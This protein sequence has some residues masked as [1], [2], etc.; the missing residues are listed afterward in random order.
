V[1]SLVM[2]VRPFGH[3][4]LRLYARVS[5]VGDRAV[6]DRP[7]I[8]AMFLDDITDT[9]GRLRAVVDDVILFTRDWEF[10]LRDVHVPVKWW[11]GDADHI[12]PLAHGEHCVGLLPDAELFIRPEES[13]LGGLGAA[14]EVLDTMLAT[15]DGSAVTATNPAAGAPGTKN[16]TPAS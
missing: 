2:A 3:E 7:E 5:P 4:A 16:R 6:F 11:H 8:E 1:S 10:S 9:G 12:V 15:W 13:H 14:R